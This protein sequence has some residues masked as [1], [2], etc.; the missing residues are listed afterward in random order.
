MEE[1]K[2]CYSAE[3][4]ALE[5]AFT[6]TGDGIATIRRR[7]LLI[8]TLIRQMLAL[9]LGQNDESASIAAVAV[10]GYGR[11]ELFPHSDIDVLYLFSTAA[12]EAAHRETVRGVNQQ[13]WDIGL[14]VS[15]VTRSIKDCERFSPDNVEFTL[16]LLDQRFV[17]GS[18]GVYEQL[19]ARVLPA[20][21]P[22]EWSKLTQNVAELARA[23]PPEIR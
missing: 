6:R 12:E 1:A 7:A 22:R 15:P 20:L 19:Q 9:A 5:Q 13:M 4:Q 16:S 18:K 14:R 17:A 10:G 21:I 3:Q 23:P 11:K 8:D 2:A